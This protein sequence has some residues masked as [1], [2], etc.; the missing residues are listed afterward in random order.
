VPT[1]LRRQR[2]RIAESRR[3]MQNLR[4]VC[5]KCN[6]VGNGVQADSG[7]CGDVGVKPED[8]L[9]SGNTLLES[10][11]L[12]VKGLN[13][14]AHTLFSP[15]MCCR[16]MQGGE[17]ISPPLL[18]AT[19]GEGSLPG[20]GPAA[21]RPGRI[22]STDGWTITRGPGVGS[23]GSLT[24]LLNR[25]ANVGCLRVLTRRRR[26]RIHSDRPWQAGASSCPLCSAAAYDR[27]TLP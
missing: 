25:D 10:L 22:Q 2:E 6:R 3:G 14:K 23:Q 9:R 11:R 21:K 27:P 8:E 15:I 13:R 19:R 18:Q 1:V 5:Q 12:T 7:L 16:G 17:R 26:T 4:P 20:R 24:V